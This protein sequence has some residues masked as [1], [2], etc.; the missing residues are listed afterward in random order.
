MAA[1]IDGCRA[2]RL[3]LAGAAACGLAHAPAF[4]GTPDQA[5]DQAAAIHGQY[6]LVAQ[7]VG[8]FASPYMGD[9]SLA[10]RQVKA[11]NDVTLY[12]GARPWQGAE[13]WVNPEIDQG[14]GLSNTLGAGGFP[15]AEAYKVGQF[16]PYFKLQRAFLRQTIA[17]GGSALALDAGINQL[18][19]VTTANRVVI[20]A[21]KMGVGDVFDTNRYAHD[22]R[23]DFLNWSLVDTGSFD[24]AANAWGYTYGVAAE[25]YQGPWT[26]RAGLYNL[27]KVPNG[28]A[29]ES[30]FRQNAIIVEGE[31]RFSL[32][33]HPGAVRVTAFRNRGLFARFDD[34]LALARATGQAPDLAPVRTM[35]D[36]LGIAM[37]AE[38]EITANLGLF[39]RAGYSD[40]TIE[41]YD[42]T[43]IDRT[44]AL[45]AALQGKAWGRPQDT[46]ALAGVVNGISSAHQRWLAAGGLGVL[47]GD[48]ALPDPGNEQIVEAYY[49]FRPVGW[50]SLTFDYQHIA[51]P[52]YNR[53]RGPANVFA[54]RVHAGF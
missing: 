43:D 39:L 44:V 47:V 45:G 4:A 40:G 16:S 29:L 37:N 7:G 33:G 46:V 21:G 54:L 19:G 28:I 38:Q 49:A 2:G 12:L 25:W 24:Y 50:G 20:T 34:A 22:P 1:W 48:G 51:N 27:S 52:G 6:T 11:T 14:F 26:L 17:L 23:G 9:N 30:D 41:T 36:R 8:S 53:D 10:P 13:I 5:S 32:G 31:R 3:A 35:R 42:F 18:R 15:S